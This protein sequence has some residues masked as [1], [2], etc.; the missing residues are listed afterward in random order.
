MKGAKVL[1]VDD[2]PDLLRALQLGLTGQGLDVAVAASGEAALQSLRQHRPDLVIL[3]LMLPGIDGLT[4]CQEIRA[5]SS[6]PIIVLSAKGGDTDKIQAL[7]LGADDYLTKPFSLGELLAR[8][9]A[10]LR[11]AGGA[12]AGAEPIFRSGDFAVDLVRRRVTVGGREVR[13][14]PTEYS[15]LK[16]LVSHAG[17]VVPRRQ[18]LSEVWGVTYHQ[19]AHYLHVYISQ[20]RRKIEEDPN[21]PR[22]ILSE[23][24]VGYRFE[25]ESEPR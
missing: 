16:V 18:L 1:V 4:V 14:T 21:H 15:L 24:G 25:V 12:Q 22:R 2:E 9:R 17:R 8:I 19:D 20:L 6:V 10:A 3:D 5:G 23:P 7:D 13:L 11:R